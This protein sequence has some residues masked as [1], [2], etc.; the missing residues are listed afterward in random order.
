MQQQEATW[1]IFKAGKQLPGVVNNEAQA[2]VVAANYVRAGQ[3]VTEILQLDRSTQKV[4]PHRLVF[5]ADEG[6]YFLERVGETNEER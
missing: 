6:H 3:R 5:D 2:R 4:I 1:L